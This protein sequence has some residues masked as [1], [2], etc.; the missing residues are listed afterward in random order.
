MKRLLLILILT[1]SLQS[2]TKA[3]DIRDFEIEGMSLGDNLLNYFTE[4]QII[5]NLAN[6]Y[7][8]KEYSVTELNST[9]LDYFI[10]QVHYKKEGKKFIIYALDGLFE[11]E[12]MQQ[13]INKKNNIAD[14]MS[15]VFK[16]TDREDRPDAKMT[17]GHG[18]MPN[19]KFYFDTEDFAE[20]TCYDYN[21]QVEDERGWKD[22]GRV[23]LAKKKLT[24]WI[25]DKAYK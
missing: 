8:D 3:D 6:Y 18:V 4:N 16:N 19:I 14:D 2:W 10:I 11:I 7:N 9:N 25:R 21:K 15:S 5:N 12:N 17:S 1:L 24:D 20:V 23:S 22:H 13:C